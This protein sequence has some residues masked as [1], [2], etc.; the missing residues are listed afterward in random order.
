MAVVIQYNKRTK[1]YYAYESQ[2]YWDKDLKQ[3][4]SHRKLIGRYNPVTKEITPTDGRMKRARERKD[5]P[6]IIS[7]KPVDNK[8]KEQLTIKTM[9]SYGISTVM[10]HIAKQT[11][12]L[13]V[14]QNSFPS[15]WEQML[16]VVFYIVTHGGVMSYIE[17]WFDETKIDFVDSFNDGQCSKL[18]SSISYE[19]RQHF[20]KEWVKF[21]SEQ[22][23]I[24]YDVTSI[25]TYSRNLELAEYGYNRDNE[26]LPMINYGMFYG[27]TS[28]MPVYYN[29]YSGSIPDVASLEY[30]LLNAQDIGINKTTF[31]IDEGFV[32]KANLSFLLE[33][34]YSF[35]T[36]MPSSKDE[37]HQLINSASIDIEDGEKWIK[38]Y[39]VYGIQK[40]VLLDGNSLYAH[41]YF[42]NTRK[43]SEIE[44]H[45]DYIDKLQMELDKLSHSKTI[46]NRYN[47]YFKIDG[48]T[49]SSFS[50]EIDHQKANKKLKSMGYFILLTNNPDLTSAEML[51]IYRGKDIIEKHFDQF[52]NDLDFGRL[53]THQMKT[54]EGKIFIGFLALILRSSMLNLI[55]RNEATKQYTFEKVLIELKKIKSVVLSDMKQ[56]LTVITKTQRIILASLGVEKNMVIG[57]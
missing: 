29:A 48:K 52:K 45:Y 46:P 56:V 2:G 17:D 3:A 18:F 43:A 47:A 25:S 35:I 51:K 21:R 19:E 15:K 26:I 24:A 12:L 1:Q 4:R 38:D 41:V 34:K 8:R 33:N 36:I 7:N 44:A 28:N 11:G 22:E 53:Q 54:T 6:D 20:F 55:K 9:Q 5:N 50:Y 40:P 10:L 27:T 14:L 23:Y 42:S 37:Y 16:A 30:M 31:V 57:E 13:E 49:P 39:K 32:S